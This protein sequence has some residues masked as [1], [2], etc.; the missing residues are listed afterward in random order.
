MKKDDQNI[1]TSVLN[2][3]KSEDIK[4]KPRW[5]FLAKDYLI[6]FFGFFSLLVG[7]LAFSALI[8]LERHGDW[9]IYKN[10]DYNIIEFI[11]ATLSYFWVIAFVTFIILAYYN[12]KH[13]KKGYK[14]SMPI[15]FFGS[16]IL[17]LVLG[18]IFHNLGVARFVDDIFAKKAPLYSKVVNPRL[19]MWMQPEKGFL[20]GSIIDAEGNQVFVLKDL[21]GDDWRVDYQEAEVLPVVHISNG[22]KINLIGRIVQAQ[23]FEAERIMPIGPGRGFHDKMIKF[24][25]EEDCPMISNPSFKMCP[26]K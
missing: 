25:F 20:T 8:Y 1:I 16:L 24:D 26:L 14:Y 6:W 19:S 13:T 23:E 18:V 12:L 3:I 10:F 9:V 22:E 11:F 2:K 7:A 5:S 21:R 4:P 17:T 15:I